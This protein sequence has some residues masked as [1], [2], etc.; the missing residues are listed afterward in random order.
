[1]PARIRPTS[2]PLIDFIN[3]LSVKEFDLLRPYV[4]IGCCDHISAGAIDGPELFWTKIAI[5][6][7][8]WRFRWRFVQHDGLFVS[9]FILVF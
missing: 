4:L 6:M 8:T 2:E 9:T 5:G 7:A 3:Y 1:M